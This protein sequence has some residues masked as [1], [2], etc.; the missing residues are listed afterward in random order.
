MTRLVIPAL[1]LALAAAGC[2][3]TGYAY[4]PAEA[5]ARTARG[6]L[7][8]RYDV[9]AWN[10]RGQVEVTATGLSQLELVPGTRVPALHVRLT[11]A[12]RESVPWALDTR[13]LVLAIAGNGAS[14]PAY[15][16]TDAG[17]PPLVTISPGERRTLDVYYPLPRGHDTA[18]SLP[19]FTLAWQ[20]QTGQGLVS[21]RTP[22]DRIAIE[23]AEEPRVYGRI[24]VG[25]GAYPYWYYDPFY[26]RYTFTYPPPFAYYPRRV[27]VRR[28]VVIA[29]HRPV[30]VPPRRPVHVARPPRR[31]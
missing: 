2:A 24:A 9:P 10:P 12:N 5:G 29:P 21:E 6:A 27:I 20:L 17:V 3:G 11:V 8:A 26:P 18:A 28:P 22:F 19:R 16:N 30:T 23:E 15:V 25:I 1:A 31:R 14:R 4:V 7:A 13:S